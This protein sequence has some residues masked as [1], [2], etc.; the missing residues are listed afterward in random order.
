MKRTTLTLFAFLFF[1]QSYGQ[2]LEWSFLANSGLYHLTGN[3]TVSTTFLNNVQANSKQ[4]YANNPYGNLFGFSYGGGFQAQHVAAG[5]FIVGLQGTYEFLRSKENINAVY[6]AGLDQATGD[7]ISNYNG[8]PSTGQSVL[9]S[10]DVDFNPYVGYRLKAKKVKIDLMPGIDLAYNLS[11]YEYGNAKDGAGQKYQT[12]YYNGTL[13]PD[14]RLRFGAAAWYKKFA[15][16]A[17]YAHGVTNF[18]SHLL[19]DN[20]TPQYTRSELIRFGVAL[21]LN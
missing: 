16:T 5:G 10:Q 17:S 18:S 14:I 1:L 4:G 13:S 2:S 19:N 9:V 12:G 15:L 6:P 8:V 20:P 3:Y 21:R 7:Y 11:V